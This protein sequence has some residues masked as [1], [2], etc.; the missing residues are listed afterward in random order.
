M[1]GVG[2]QLTKKTTL[3]RKMS[4]RGNTKAPRYH[5]GSANLDRVNRELASGCANGASMA[6]LIRVELV[7]RR[8]HR[9]TGQRRATHP[10]G[11]DRSRKCEASHVA[12]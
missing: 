9:E 4:A 2:D 5:Q 12:A 6:Y 7:P 10:N 3:S 1:E 8:T 11:A